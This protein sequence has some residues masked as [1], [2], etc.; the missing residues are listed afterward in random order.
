MNGWM[1][2][3][4]GPAA[5][6]RLI[7]VI[8]TVA[9][10]AVAPLLEARVVKGKLGPVPVT[11]ARLFAAS[12][13]TVRVVV[14]DERAPDPLTAW[15]K[16]GSAT[17]T[18][19]CGERPDEVPAAIERGARDALTVLGLQ[20]GSDISLEIAIKEMRV[21]VV[22]VK[23]SLTSHVT[24]YMVATAAVR[25]GET[26]VAPASPLLIALYGEGVI[27]QA[28]ARLGWESAA[29]VLP[30]ALG[31]KPDPAAVA[32]LLA[33]MNVTKDEKL[34]EQG[35]FWSAFAGREDAATIPMLSKLFH[36]AKNPSVSEA[37]LLAL[38]EMKAPGVKD[39]VLAILA[40]REKLKDWEP[41]KDTRRAWILLEALAL[42]GERDLTA[43]M[44]KVDVYPEMLTD[45]VGF[46]ETGKIPEVSPADAKA[47]AAL[48]AEAQA[49]LSK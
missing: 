28:F 8:P 34:L 39:E 38:A 24:A 44:P 6:S 42:F 43:R 22:S 33:Q 35:A 37:E 9:L 14:R 10:L 40:G 47:L 20:A 15:G 26:E 5:R 3:R 11:V 16:F 32:A 1:T 45:L 29:R 18:G 46:R 17:L 25:S 48:R 19:F 27:A 41:K 30:G 2:R 4:N 21:F 7:F 23:Y 31:L 12:S 36:T 13:Q 49:K